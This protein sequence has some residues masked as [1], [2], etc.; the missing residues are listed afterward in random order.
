MTFQQGPCVTARLDFKE[1]GRTIQANKDFSAT[2]C[3]F[4]HISFV[5]AVG[6]CCNES[7]LL[8]KEGG[9]PTVQHMRQLTAFFTVFC[10]ISNSS[11]PQNVFSF[12]Q[13]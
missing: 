7:T 4:I 10:R 11:A 1:C 5:H 9:L 3:S 8:W 2:V 13:L 6:G 12:P